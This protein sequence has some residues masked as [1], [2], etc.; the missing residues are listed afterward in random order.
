MNDTLK[1]TI[2]KKFIDYLNSRDIDALTTVITEDFY[3]SIYHGPIIR[4][5]RDNVLANIK[6]RSSEQPKI[7][8]K[9]LAEFQLGQHVVLHERILLG[10]QALETFE[11]ISIFTFLGDKI[12]SIDFIKQ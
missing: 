8:I 9:I 10:S 5:G 1:L 11:V 2:A 3:E 12:K 6:S 4:K 7:Y